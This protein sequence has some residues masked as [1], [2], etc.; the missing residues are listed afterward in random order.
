MKYYIIAGEASGDLHG[1]N[2]MK[3]IL[4]NDPE[5]E[6]RIW[7]G[8]LMQSVGGTLV[9]HYRDLAFMGFIEVL[10]NLRTILKNIKFCKTDILEY[11]PDTII[12]ID[13]PGFNMRIAEF[14]KNHGIRTDYYI[15]PQIWAWKEGRIKKIK[16][17]VDQMYVILPFEKDFYEKKHNFPVQFVGHPLIDAIADR[18]QV[19]DKTF[20]EENN[21][22]LEKPIIALLPGSRKQE[23]TNMLE[24]M[25]SVTE[26]FTDY[27][28]VIAGAPSQDFS[29]YKQFISKDNVKFISNK[30]YDLLSLSYAALVTSG[31]ATLETALFKVPEIVCYKTS[32][33][34]YQIAKRLINLKFISL[35]NLI[36]DKEIVVELI[37]GEF[38]TKRLTSELEKILTTEKREEIFENYY[39]LEEKLGGKG[40]SENTAKLIIENI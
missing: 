16:R 35:V 15:S 27:E 6:F 5:A 10:M 1:S 9:K 37:Q 11:K 13:Y 2:L 12:F 31:T 38:N 18:K 8:D 21:L 22:D 34:S 40:A 20:R 3:S 14:A 17:D 33:I 28:F 25:L 32:N 7:G 39:D 23:I 24:V 29:F 36:M 4:K 30:T 26:K 19:D